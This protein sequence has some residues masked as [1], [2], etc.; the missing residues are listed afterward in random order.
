MRKEHRRCTF[1]PSLSR[2]P[3]AHLCKDAKLIGDGLRLGDVDVIHSKVKTKGERKVSFEQFVYALALVAEARVS[4][5]HACRMQRCL[6]TGDH[7]S[8]SCMRFLFPI[9]TTT[10]R[11]LPHLQSAPCISICHPTYRAPP[12]SQSET[13]DQVVASVVKSGPP[14]G[15]GTTE[16]DKVRLHDDKDAYTW[17]YKR[18]GS[19]KVDGPALVN[20]GQASIKGRQEGDG[21]GAD[22][23]ARAMGAGAGGD[24]GR[25]QGLSRQGS[26]AR[27]DSLTESTGEGKGGMG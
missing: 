13:L 6:S 11:A 17:V 7:R 21:R 26:L 8:Q 24:A 20:A 3:Q 15:H 2:A 14:K 27:R 19:A 9:S 18:G 25:G 12:F 4:G 16:T 22:R 5:G 23:G 1:L 10:H